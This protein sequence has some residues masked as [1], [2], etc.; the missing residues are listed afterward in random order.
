MS[1]TH[2]MACA[3][4][5]T[6]LATKSRKTVASRK[7]GTAFL[8]IPSLW[9]GTPGTTQARHQPA[10][11]TRGLGA[12]YSPTGSQPRFA[13]APS[14][15]AFTSHKSP[16]VL[17]SAHLGKQ[18][19]PFQTFN[20]KKERRHSLFFLIVPLLEHPLNLPFPSPSRASPESHEIVTIPFFESPVSVRP[21]FPRESFSEV[22][23][24]STD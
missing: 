3:R 4:V 24:S 11:S 5:S 2:T 6:G 17:A 1:P 7:P 22:D 10:V 14:A 12:D 16:I 9:V 19:S 21:L 20:R 18:L 23:V 8:R 15:N 13:Q